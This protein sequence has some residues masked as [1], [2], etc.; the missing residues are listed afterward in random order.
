MASS[1]RAIFTHLRAM[2]DAETTSP[3]EYREVKQ[4][5]PSTSSA[6]TNNARASIINLL[7]VRNLGHRQRSAKVIE[8]SRKQPSK[9]IFVPVND[10]REF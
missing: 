3:D 2:F 4:E 1:D 7:S 6:E 5:V 9:E 8:A 10:C